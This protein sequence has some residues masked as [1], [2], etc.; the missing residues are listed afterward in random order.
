[1]E[2]SLEQTPI[3]GLLVVRLPVH[4]DTRGWFKENWQRE[5]MTALGLPDFGPV[6]NNMSFNARRGATRGIHAEP[7]DKFVSVATG[8]VF[9]AWVDLREGPLVRHDVPRRARP[10]RRGLRAARRRQ[11]L[12][13]ARGRHGLQLPRQRPLAPRH[14]LPRAEPRRPDAAIPWPIPLD[15]GRRLREGP[16]QPGP[17]RRRPPC[18]R[19]DPD[20][21][22][23]GAARPGAA[24][25]FPAADLVDRDELD[26]TDPA[27]VAAWPW[28]E[29]AVVLNAAAYTAVDAAETPEGRVAAWA[30]NAAGARP[31]GAAWRSEH[32]FTLVHYSSDY[33]FDGTTEE[34]SEDEPLSPL[35]V[36]G[37]SKAAGDLAV[38]TAPAT[39]CCAR[40]GWSATATTS[41]AP[42]S[43]WPRRASPRAW[44]TTRSAGSRSPRAGPGHRPPRVDRGAVRHLQRHQR[45]PGIV[46]GGPGPGRLRAQRALAGRRHRGQHGGVLRRQGRVAAAGAQLAG[47]DK[48]R[49]TGSSRRTP[50]P[51]SSATARSCG[52][53]R[54]RGGRCRPRSV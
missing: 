51:P 22:Q 7:W 27:A 46:L 19:E 17:R 16:R 44:S 42:C 39:T 32:R 41:C 35:G 18:R 34:H 36:Y 21:R 1:M 8:R 54:P 43:R 3:P 10:R 30:A 5:K 31:A 13:G 9:A 25:D 14:R 47:L 2:P 53:S 38:A 20:H 11:R 4:E 6:Q 15:R 48:L 29:Y 45:R 37:Q 12:P 49:A 33:V 24:A 26:L 40:P 52:R 28:H 23:Q 50:S